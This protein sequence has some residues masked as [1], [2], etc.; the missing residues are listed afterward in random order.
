MDLGAIETILK[1]WKSIRSFNRRVKKQGFP[2]PTRE[3]FSVLKTFFL[4]KYFSGGVYIGVL[5][6]F[7]AEGLS[8]E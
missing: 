3:H 7:I 4:E 8:V 1:Q 6:E 2:K 5:K